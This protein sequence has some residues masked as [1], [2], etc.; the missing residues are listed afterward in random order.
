MLLSAVFLSL[1]RLLGMWPYFHMSV[2]GGFVNI[3]T[4]AQGA[5]DRQAG[6][7]VAALLTTWG[8]WQPSLEAHRRPSVGEALVGSLGG[9]RADQQVG[10]LPLM[11]HTIATSQAPLGRGGADRSVSS[12]AQWAGCC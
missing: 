1:V 5:G 4:L 10:T 9:R 12:P 3:R 7:D 2:S 8:S 6:D 11:V